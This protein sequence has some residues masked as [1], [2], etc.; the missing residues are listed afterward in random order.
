MFLPMFRISTAV[1]AL[2]VAGLV[3]LACSSSG[4]KS[5]AGDGAAGGQV[6]STISSG[7]TGGSSGSGGAGG[8]ST[9]GTGGTIGSG[10]RMGGTDGA[11]GSGGCG[12]LCISSVPA[13]GG[14]TVGLPNFNNCGNGVLDPGEWC[15]DGNRFSGDGCNALCQL[16][17]NWFCPIP[18]QPCVDHRVCGNKVLTSNETCDDGNTV[19]GDGCSGDCQMIEP[20]WRCPVPGRPCTAICGNQLDGSVTCDAGNRQGGRCGDGVLTA[21]EKCDCGDGTVPVPA[22]C[23][24]PNN[25]SMYGGCTTKC[26]WGPFCGDGIIQSPPE[27]CDLGKLNGSDLS[28]N[29]CR[30]GCMKPHYCGDGIVDTDQGEQCDMGAVN[31]VPLDANGNPSQVGVVECST[32]CMITVPYCGDGIIEPGEQCDLGNH[33]GVLQE[34]LGGT[35]TSDCHWIPWHVP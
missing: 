22:G 27:Q 13:T 23:F 24:G 12:I 25:D 2:F 9:G 31:G 5:R 15:D 30:F 1:V 18:G 35:C 7:T 19:S 33:N 3:G 16:E 4:L 14:E 29:G 11:V 28:A 10:G 21:G 8:G 6:G 26:M 20:G 17:A 34:D 32:D